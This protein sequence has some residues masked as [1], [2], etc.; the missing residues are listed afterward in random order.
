MSRFQKISRRQLQTLATGVCLVPAVA[1]TFRF[2][3]EGFGANPV[4]DITH[5][6]GEWGLR[7]LL[8]SL[9]I[10]PARRWLGWAWAAP[11]RRTFGLASFAHAAFHLATWAYL[12]LGLDLSAIVA[13]VIERPYVTAGMSAFVLLGILAATSTRRSIKRLG[14]RWIRLHQLIYPAAILATLHFFW[15]IKADYRPAIVHGGLLAILLLARVAWRY[16]QT[17]PGK[18]AALE[19]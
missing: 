6:T 7:F 17:R 4:D 15:L 16:K 18:P 1:L 5:V 12:D 8:L 2:V 3:T 10:T 13:D 11:L 14:K 19:S 9:A